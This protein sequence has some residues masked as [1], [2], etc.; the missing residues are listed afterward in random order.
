[1][2]DD[3]PVSYQ[4]EPVAGI[5]GWEPDAQWAS[6]TIDELAMAL[7]NA[8][9]PEAY[10]RPEHYERTFSFD[11]VGAK[12]ANLLLAQLDDVDPKAAAWLRERRRM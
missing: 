12:M 6:V 10:V 3:V 8:K 7:R 9:A 2:A 4:M 5:Y 1:V 11:A